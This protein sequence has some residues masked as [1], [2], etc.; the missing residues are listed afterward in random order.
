MT[1]QKTSIRG[2]L[3]QGLILGLVLLGIGAIVHNTV[4]NLSARG[5]ASGFS[6]LSRPAGFD[7]GFSLIPFG[8][9]S[10]FLDAFA[11]GLCNTLL[12]A[13]LGII[14]AS[15]LGLIVALLRLAPHP[16]LRLIGGTYVE[17]VRNIPLLLH[18]FFWYFAVLR[19]LPSPRQSLS[20]GPDIFLNIRGLYLPFPADHSALWWL[21]GALILG[22]W[23]GHWA[24]RKALRQQELEGRLPR[25]Q[26]LPFVLP[27]LFP[28][29]TLLLPIW[30]L[31]RPELQGFNFVGGLQLVPELVALVVALSFYTAAFIGEIIRAGI[32]AVAPGQR[33]AAQALGLSSFDTL[34]LIILPQAL[35]VI[36]PPL[37]SQ[38]LNVTKNSSLAAAIA[39]PDL[40]LV[41][42]GTAL[43]VTGQAVEIMALTM[44]V[45]LLI[46]LLIS[47]AMHVFQKQ[48]L[49][50]EG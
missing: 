2:Y 43:N 40:V 4:A 41:F 50:Y 30:S 14:G 44:A 8:E 48:V 13:V 39:F 29:I 42:A 38:Y 9:G 26:S 31:S 27:L 47:F 10:T 22:L 24:R 3:W 21:L 12:V 23:V 18:L 33:E 37:T 25:W 28:L 19:Q 15:V 16:L 36:L 34:R 46:S 49:H 1:R 5:I 11:V 20:L 7:I 32:L 6:F 45:Y 35:R 17:I